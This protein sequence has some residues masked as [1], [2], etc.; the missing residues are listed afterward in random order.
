MN[1]DLHIHSLY[2]DGSDDVESIVKK[3]KALQLDLI[4][5][6]DHNTLSGLFDLKK[7]AS[8]YHQNVL[9]GVELSTMYQDK[10]IHLLGYFPIDSDFQSHDFDSIRNFIN[11]NKKM[12]TKQ[13]EAMILNL[14]AIWNEISLTD[15]YHFTNSQNINRVHIAQYLVSKRYVKDINEAF[16]KYIGYH[17]PY[18]VKKKTIDI[19][20][21]IDAIHQ[22]K[23]KA[24]IAHLGQ[25]HLRQ[26]EDFMKYCIENGVDGFECYHPFN[27]EKMIDLIL[28]YQDTMLLTAGSD[29]HG[30]N[31][32]N[33]ALGKNYHFI[34]NDHQKKIYEKTIVKTY[35]FFMNS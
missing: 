32:K 19:K 24:I 29:Y 12:K 31:K 17:C 20:Q 11:Q 7:Y 25:Y 35:H 26:L 4:A 27:D 1:I 18:Y 5:L 10:E 21:G 6:T 14:K 8:L 13:N 16:E 34:M 22:A 23:G 9:A 3:S 15:F 30:S 2:S 28:K 33:N